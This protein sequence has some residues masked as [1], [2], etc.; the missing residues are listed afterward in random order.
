METSFKA[1]EW[2]KAI[3]PNITPEEK[4]ELSGLLN[5]LMKWGGSEWF[6]DPVR[7]APVVR[8][9]LS[10][11]RTDRLS[12]LLNFQ[13]DVVALNI[14]D[15]PKIITEP[16]SLSSIK[17][18]LASNLR[19]SH[20]QFERDMQLIVDNARRYNGPDSAVGQ[21]ASKLEAQWHVFGAGDGSK[22]RKDSEG[23]GGASK[24]AKH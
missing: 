10:I 14:P 4:K 13:V 11:V 12:L 20:E 22:K 23:G 24:K 2:P 5:K 7:L 8:S 16:R 9:H 1:K 21:A 19:Y 15:Y 3:S 17:A 6:R 18:N